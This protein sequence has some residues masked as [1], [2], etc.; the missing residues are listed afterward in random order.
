MNACADCIYTAQT[1]DAQ[2]IATVI[3]VQFHSQKKKYYLLPHSSDSMGI[4]PIMSLFHHSQDNEKTLRFIYFF[5]PFAYV[6]KGN[7]IL[8]LCSQYCHLM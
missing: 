6:L 1:Q 7:F 5:P 8:L 2:K 3:N 4:R